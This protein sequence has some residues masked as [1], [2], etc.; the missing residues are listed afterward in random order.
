MG[1]A[2]RLTL[3]FTVCSDLYMSATPV[4]SNMLLRLAGTHM[5]RL[6]SI[7]TQKTTIILCIIENLVSA[8]HYR[9]SSVMVQI[10]GIGSIVCKSRIKTTETGLS[11]V[12]LNCIILRGHILKSTGTIV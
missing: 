9:F 4:V 10:K 5:A 2:Q 6:C 3:Q 12:L 7:I 1:S 11:I 8:T